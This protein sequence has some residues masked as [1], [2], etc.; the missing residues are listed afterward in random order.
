ME[1][2]NIEL[3]T[4]EAKAIIYL[5]KAAVN[6]CHVFAAAKVNGEFLERLK[7]KIEAEMLKA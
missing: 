5:I 7:D 3:T 6:L 4:G 2:I 1:K